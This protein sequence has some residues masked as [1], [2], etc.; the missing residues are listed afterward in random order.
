MS[1]KSMANQS[2]AEAISGSMGTESSS[3]TTCQSGKYNHVFICLYERYK[4]YHIFVDI[5][6]L[7]VDRCL[8]LIVTFIYSEERKLFNCCINTYLKN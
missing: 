7:P 4:I 5:L 1:A 8:M 2:V 3:V 6:H